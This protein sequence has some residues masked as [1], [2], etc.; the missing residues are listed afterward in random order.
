MKKKYIAPESQ[1]VGINLEGMVA[2]SRISIDET[3]KN[4]QESDL[5]SERGGW[6]SDN[7]SEE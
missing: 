6:R 1:V 2:A 5:L 3:T 4:T 7:W